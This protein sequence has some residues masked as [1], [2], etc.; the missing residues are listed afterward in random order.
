MLPDDAQ[1]HANLGTS[2]QILAR[3]DEA[4]A[5]YEEAVRL[6]PE[7]AEAHFGRATLRL[8]DGDFAGGFEEFEWR[9]KCTTFR[10]RGFP[11]PRWDGAP[12]EGR[13][14]LLYAEQ[15]LGDA[16][17]FVRFAAEAKRQGGHVIVECQPP[18]TTILATCPASDRTIAIGSSLPPF[19][20][21]SP[22]LSLPGILK[23]TADQFS[24]GPYL[25]ADPRLVDTWRQRLEK[26]PG[27][28]IGLCWRGNPDHQCDCQRS[29][30]LASF[31]PW[32]RCPARNAS[33]CKRRPT[34]TR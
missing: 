11:Q 14:I 10:D 21:H 2:F 15:G 22:L 6:N 27:F 28:R 25:A 26:H 7:L 13:T 31:A 32:P 20:V 17:N 29:I 3:F 34:P 30:S 33:A 16:I 12:L 24:R 1:A 19:D 9:W 8:R 4:R 5:C 23:L 18:L